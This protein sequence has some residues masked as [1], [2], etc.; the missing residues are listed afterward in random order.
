MCE[1]S[2]EQPLQHPLVVF[3]T[4]LQSRE[5]VHVVEAIQPN[6]HILTPNTPYVGFEFEPVGVG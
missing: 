5:P 6:N 4:N 2:Y 3:L 1:A